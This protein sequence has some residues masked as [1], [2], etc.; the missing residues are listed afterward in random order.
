MSGSGKSSIIGGTGS[1][2]VGSGTTSTGGD[3][4]TS[5][6]GGDVLLEPVLP[7]ELDGGVDGLLGGVTG[8]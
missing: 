4:T 2:G 5:G 7:E 6:A 3:G 1:T 8:V